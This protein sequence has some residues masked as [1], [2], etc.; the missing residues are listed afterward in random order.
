MLIVSGSMQRD[1]A[2]G[3]NSSVRQ[4]DVGPAAG[5]KQRSVNDTPATRRFHI[6]IGGQDVHVRL[7]RYGAVNFLYDVGYPG[8]HV[9]DACSCTGPICTPP[10]SKIDSHEARMTDADAARPDG[11]RRFRA[12][13]AKAINAIDAA[14]QRLEKAASVSSS[15]P[16]DLFSLAMM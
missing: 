11:C 14:P 8:Q 3:L 16:K 4:P 15:V 9:L 13:T 7:T 10:R 12:S 6:D 1:D 5:T 2:Q